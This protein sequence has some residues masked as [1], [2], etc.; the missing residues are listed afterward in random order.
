MIF[1]EPDE[2]HDEATSEAPSRPAQSRV[3]QDAAN[4][5]VDHDGPDD[6]NDHRSRRTL[7]Q[8]LQRSRH[9]RHDGVH[10]RKNFV[11]ESTSP[12]AGER[13]E[14]AAA[15]RSAWEHLPAA[16]PSAHFD[17]EEVVAGDRCV[18]R[19]RYTWT[20]NGGGYVRGVDVLTVRD[21]KI[22][23]KLAYVKG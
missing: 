17:A 10:D 19:W 21:G 18:V 12:H 1:I 7:Q 16:S 2:L 20:E 13:H 14:S 23:E 9:R 5:E 3:R 11:F 6:P 8:R 15:I 22:A 4:R